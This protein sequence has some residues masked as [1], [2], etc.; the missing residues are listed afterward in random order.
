MDG[1]LNGAMSQEE[2]DRLVTLIPNCKGNTAQFG[3]SRWRG[4]FPQPKVWKTEEY[5]VYFLFSK[6]R[7]WGEKTRH[8]AA[9][10]LCGVAIRIRELC[11][12][13][14]KGM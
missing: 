8:P 11:K 6:L 7:G 2:A 1:T 3:K 13:K 12:T 4:I 10:D 14:M 5:L 9:D